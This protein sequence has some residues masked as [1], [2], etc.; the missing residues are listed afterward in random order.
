[1]ELDILIEENFANC[2]ESGWFGTVA[3]ECLKT[4]DLPDS[5]EVSLVIVNQEKI[6]KINR[7][8]LDKDNV[9]DVITFSMLPGTQKTGEQDIN[10]ITAPDEIVHLGEIFIS[11]PQALLQAEQQKHSIPQE[12]AILVVH[13]ILHLLGYQDYD[14]E[15]RQRMLKKGDEVLAQ[16][17]LRFT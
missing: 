8:Y 17:G 16:T 11:F 1:M 4:L 9:T 13:G 2:P 10:F 6:R 15:S 12:L 14:P 7:Q 5:I 3:G